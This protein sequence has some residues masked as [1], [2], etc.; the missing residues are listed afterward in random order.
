MAALR[1][2][3]SF[4]GLCWSFTCSC[5]GV[6]WSQFCGPS[7]CSCVLGSCGVSV[8]PFCRL[9]ILRTLPCRVLACGFLWFR[10]PS[11]WCFLEL[12]TEVLSSCFQRLRMAQDGCCLHFVRGPLPMAGAVFFLVAVSQVGPAHLHWV[13]LLWAWCVCGLHSFILL[14]FLRD[15]LTLWVNSVFLSLLIAS[16]GLHCWLFLSVLANPFWGVCRGVPTSSLGLLALPV[17]GSRAIA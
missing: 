11:S 12:F 13:P 4:S 9:G 10:G 5:G 14:V 3:S 16:E 8:V 17:A 7:C 6:V 2:W 15:G 1:G